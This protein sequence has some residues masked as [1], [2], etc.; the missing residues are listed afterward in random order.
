MG[1]TMLED[2]RSDVESTWAE[3][4]ELARGITGLAYGGGSMLNYIVHSN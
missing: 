2:I 1:A 3:R 4:E